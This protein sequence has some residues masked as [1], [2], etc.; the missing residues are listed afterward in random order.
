MDTEISILYNVLVSQFFFFQTFS[1][2]VPN[3]QKVGF[4]SWAIVG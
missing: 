2:A 1:W 3:R 4:G